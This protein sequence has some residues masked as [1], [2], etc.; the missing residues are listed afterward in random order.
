MATIILLF[1]VLAAIA[2]YIYRRRKRVAQS[3]A[4][5]AARPLPDGT[6]EACTN[7][8]SLPG[9]ISG[10]GSLMLVGYGS[11]GANLVLS[12]LTAT[13]RSGLERAIGSI[14][15]IE[16][17]Q[18]VQ[19]D[20]GNRLPDV[21]KNRL[22]VTEAA[23]LAGGFGN[24][25]I[26]EVEGL[27]PH[28]TRRVI[29]AAEDVIDR[30]RRLSPRSAEPAQVICFTSPGPTGYTGHV[31]TK[32]LSQE[33]PVSQF[34]GLM[35]YSHVD[36]MRG[37][38]KEVIDS[39]LRAGMHGFV[40]ADNLRDLESPDRIPELNDFA[41]LCTVLALL[42]STR[43]AA[44][45][46]SGNNLFRQLIPEQGGLAS[47]RASI[48]T[49]PAHPYTGN[50][51]YV[52]R[53]AVTDLVIR[54]LARINDA[55]PAVSARLGHELTMRYDVVVAPIIPAHLRQLDTEIRESIEEATPPARN[56]EIRFSPVAMPISTVKPTC[57]LV[58][59]SLQALTEPDVHLATVSSGLFL[60]INTP[61][62]GSAPD[63]ATHSDRE[64]LTSTNGTGPAIIEDPNVITH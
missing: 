32:R 14:L 9:V 37:Q 57:P 56:T 18:D 28:W 53:E 30:H 11:F 5:I 3:N 1:I 52:H 54:Q 17:D 31:A 60:P 49:L 21:F 7:S 33:F 12:V 38:I 63:E 34:I 4:D 42:T 13:H 36:R 19:L 10:S 24:R 35:A 43:R 16:F 6:A 29:R 8:D 59:L 51:Y 45:G 40:V 48:S 20:F 27:A 26:S 15:L 25:P 64:H 50:R 55:S 58:V 61:S 2:A 23:A 39:H 46:A 62:T 47:F 44:I 22:V 41:M